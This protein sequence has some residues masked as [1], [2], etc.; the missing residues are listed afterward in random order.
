MGCGAGGG[1]GYGAEAGELEAVAED[2][3]GREGARASG[4][5]GER[6]VR[7]RRGY[8]ECVGLMMG[9]F[10]DM[11]GVKRVSVDMA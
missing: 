10:A 8:V 6:E 2:R 5:K 11:R 3:Q 1:K 4:G 7:E 9:E